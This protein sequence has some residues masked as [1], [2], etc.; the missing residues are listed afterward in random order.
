MEDSCPAG[1][2]CVVVRGDGGGGG[3]KS[4]AVCGGSDWDLCA[5]ISGAMIRA[6]IRYGNNFFFSLTESWYDR[7]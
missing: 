1:E 3:K 2:K 6:G 4:G 7:D 5:R